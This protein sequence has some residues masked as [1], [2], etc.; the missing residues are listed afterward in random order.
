MSIQEMK[1]DFSSFITDLEYNAK[2]IYYETLAKE[3]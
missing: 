3:Q 2:L 1:N